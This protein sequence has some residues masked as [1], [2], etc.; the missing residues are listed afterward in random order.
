VFAL[1][2]NTIGDRG[3]RALS[4][5]SNLREILLRHTRTTAAGRAA[6]S[7]SLPE[8]EIVP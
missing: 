5:L 4:G 8:L 6:L 3:I 1:P 7:K 2:V